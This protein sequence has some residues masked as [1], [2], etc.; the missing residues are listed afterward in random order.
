M[1]MAR[2]SCT[3]NVQRG[4]IHIATLGL[5]LA[6][7]KDLLQRVQEGVIGKQVQTCLD[8]QAACPECGR[9]RR[10]KDTDTTLMRTLFG[11]LHLRSPRWWQC[12]CQHNR[13]APLAR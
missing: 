13:H 6:E 1:T 2:Q 10:H 4:D 9:P 11:T 3:A 8:E 12:S 5:Q 7:A